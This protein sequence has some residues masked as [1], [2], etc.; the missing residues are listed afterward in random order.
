LP[1]GE[2]AHGGARI[3]VGTAM[4][5]LG[6]TRAGP[7]SPFRKGESKRRQG[8]SAYDSLALALRSKGMTLK[9]IGRAV[10]EAAGRPPGPNPSVVLYMLRRAELEP[11][12]GVASV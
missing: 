2:R 4:R 10:G 5:A 1:S 12:G 7:G 9:E 8:W 3:A 6:W 11:K